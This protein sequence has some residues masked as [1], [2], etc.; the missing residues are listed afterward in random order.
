[1]DLAFF[2][3]ASSFFGIF[4]FKIPSMYLA[5]DFTVLSNHECQIVLVAKLA[6]S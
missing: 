4:T 3:L 6:F 2:D 5:D 1:M